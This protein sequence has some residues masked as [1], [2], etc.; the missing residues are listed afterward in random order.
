MNDIKLELTVD[1]ANM[2]LRVLGQH[3]F[4]EVAAL[5]SKIKQQGEP[6]VA[7]MKPAEAETAETAAPAA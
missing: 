6:Q 1:E 4:T 2:V 5:I 7:A 3:P